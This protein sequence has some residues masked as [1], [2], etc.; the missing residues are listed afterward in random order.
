[1]KRRIKILFTG[2]DWFLG[3]IETCLYNI[4]KYL[5]KENIQ[6][7]FLVDYETRPCFYNELLSLGCGFHFVPSRRNNYI[8]NIKAIKKILIIE[9]YDVLH[10]NLNSLSYITPC[11]LANKLGV[12]IIL[13]SHNA[14]SLRSCFSRLLHFINYYR[15]PQNVKYIACSDKA[16][17]W[18]FPNKKVEIIRN[19]VDTELMKFSFEK[20]K[21]IRKQLNIEERTT[22]IIHIGAF[23]AQKNHSLIIDIFNK[24]L[25]KNKQSI[26]LLVGK[27]E[28][29]EQI[30]NKVK[31]LNIEKNVRFLGTRNDI[32]NLLSGSDYFLFPSLYEGFP[33]SLIE[34]EASG[35]T[36]II[37]DVI[38]KQACLPEL[39]RI[40]P[41]NSNLNSWVNELQ[42]PVVQNRETF[43]DIINSDWKL[44]IKFEIEQLLRIYEELLS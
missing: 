16:A 19:G 23:R 6:I 22:I 24:Y 27:G 5:I 3:G 17:K 37:S 44:G 29:E 39:C 41:L 36:C 14:G 38:T 7:D 26:L 28:L 43:D 21:E 15:L 40:V 34:A 2:L 4:S 10:C 8:G 32:S 25:E 30:R 42:K 9:K 13:H 31:E 33:C 35:L 18:M 20:R 12:K 11:L 1:M